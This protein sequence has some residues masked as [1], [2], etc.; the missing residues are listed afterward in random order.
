MQLIDM[1][2]VSLCITFYG[3]VTLRAIFIRHCHGVTT[4]F[5]PVTLN[6]SFANDEIH[7]GTNHYRFFSKFQKL[8]QF[9][10]KMLLLK[11]P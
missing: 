6:N 5:K 9:Y 7:R 1:V 4:A 8:H 2:F 11:K 3:F 10:N